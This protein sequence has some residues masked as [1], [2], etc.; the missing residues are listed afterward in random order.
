MMRNLKDRTSYTG[1]LYNLFDCKFL[2]DSKPDFDWNIII[3]N[4]KKT[5]TVSHVYFAIQFLNSIVPNLLPEKIN[6]NSSFEN[7]FKKYCILLV[8][9]RFFLGRMKEKGHEM[10][11]KD[12]FSS[13]EFFKEYLKLKP[14]YFILKLGII[15][16]NPFIAEKILNRA[17]LHEN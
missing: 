10:K 1:I 16:K 7:E 3:Q 8:Y 17:C 2:I 11:I 13:F 14:K 9:Q 4:A 12:L 15:R 6:I 5:E